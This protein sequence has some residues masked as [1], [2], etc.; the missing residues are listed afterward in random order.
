LYSFLLAR[1]GSS[2]ALFAEA[3]YAEDRDSMLAG[4]DAGDEF[5]SE[6]GEEDDDLEQDAAKHN[7]HV[8]GRESGGNVRVVLGRTLKGE[9]FLIYLQK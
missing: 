4:R 7:S 9:S 6:I 2:D 1:D 3:H 8:N 5:V